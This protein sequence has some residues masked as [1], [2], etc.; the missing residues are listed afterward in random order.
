MASELRVPFATYRDAPKLV[1]KLT[2]LF[3]RLQPMLSKACDGS[4]RAIEKALARLTRGQRLAYAIE[5]LQM[6]V[7]NGG[8]DQ[9]FFNSAAAFAR[10]ALDG[11][12][13]LGL[14]SFAAIAQDAFAVFPGGKVPRVR[15]ERQRMLLDDGLDERLAALKLDGKWYRSFT[16]E[17]TISKA[18]LAYVDAHPEE[19]FC[20]AT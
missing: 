15:N 9:Y 4:E 14:D 8:F 20:D 2:A 19:F 17:E 7:G 18:V 5:Q 3:A 11:L 6:E 16:G 12:R 13:V 10:E 1:D